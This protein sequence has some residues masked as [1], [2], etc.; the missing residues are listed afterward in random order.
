MGI[1]SRYMRMAR[2]ATA[3]G[4]AFVFFANGFIFSNW[5]VRIPT[6]KETLGINDA[7][8]GIALVFL[9]IGA[10]VGMPVAGSLIGRLGSGRIAATIGSL[11]VA[12]FFIVGLADSLPLLC[13]ALLLLGL[14][15]GAMDV[16][17]N[18]QADATETAIGQR[19]MSACHAMWSLGLAFGTIPAGIF[20]Q[21]GVPVAIHLLTVG[22][23]VAVGVV[24]AARV[25]S[26]DRPH[27]GPAAPA[28]ALP[29]GPLL[30]FGLICFC[31]AIVEGA[32]NDWIAVYVEDFLALGPVS[33]A[34]T[35][36]AFATA[37]LIAR[38]VGDATTERFGAAMVVRVG[39]LV[40]AIGLVTALSGL[41]AL[42]IVGFFAV[43]LGVA[44]IF[45][46][47]FRAA[48]RLP[49][50]APGPS[51]ASAVTLGYAGFL[52]GPAAIGFVAQ[53]TSLSIALAMLIPLCLIGAVL[54]RALTLA[55]D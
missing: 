9:A 12:L 42:M 30:F 2:S 6:V 22:L 25:A 21:L 4:V 26:P 55:E 54:A 18:A 11:Y 32:M 23:P 20:A 39:L 16:A 29:R 19:I 47:V 7:E 48:G 13:A 41:L 17:M 31:G 14:G 40:A 27:E 52:L 33:A 50:H 5:V 15:N 1:V 34:T 49:G 51:M 45:P 37:M 28:F 43:G 3:L 38:I 24:I 36:G 10:L 46:A 35:Y 53:A 44:G 8:L